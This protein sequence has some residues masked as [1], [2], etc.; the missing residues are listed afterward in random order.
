MAK[1]DSVKAGRAIVLNPDDAVGLTD[2]Q[3]RAHL[4]KPQQPPQRQWSLGSPS[5]IVDINDYCTRCLNCDVAGYALLRGFASH[6]RKLV[7]PGAPSPLIAREGWDKLFALYRSAAG[8][9]DLF[10]LQH[11]QSVAVEPPSTDKE[12]DIPKDVATGEQAVDNPAAG[13]NNSED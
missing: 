7:G 11:I 2:A 5:A 10:T 13:T 8:K 3:K 4:P 12:A 1:Q 9:A 6:V